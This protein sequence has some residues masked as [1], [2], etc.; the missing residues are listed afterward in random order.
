[1]PQVTSATSESFEKYSAMRNRP[2]DGRRCKFLTLWRA[3]TT[4][5]WVWNGHGVLRYAWIRIPGATVKLQDGARKELRKAYW[6]P[7]I[8]TVIPGWHYGCWPG[9]L[10]SRC[11]GGHRGQ[12]QRLRHE[13]IQISFRENQAASLLSGSFWILPFLV[14]YDSPVI[15][16]A[17]DSQVRFSGFLLVCRLS[18]TGCW[19]IVPAMAVLGIKAWSHLKVTL[20][21]SNHE[22]WGERVIIPK[23]DSLSGCVT[24]WWQQPSRNS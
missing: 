16:F 2:Y 14:L 21:V 7:E 10:A 20:F 9:N 19:P 4:S 24:L 13:D 11:W 12:P 3:S 8:E 17:L 18:I 5:S 22:R 23:Y 15:Y 6:S 1:M